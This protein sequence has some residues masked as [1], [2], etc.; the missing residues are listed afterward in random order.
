M[1]P[2]ILGRMFVALVLACA[3]DVSRAQTSGTSPQ[4][5]S[6][7][8]NQS[9]QQ[10]GYALRVNTRVVLTDVTVTDSKGNPVAGLPQSAFHIL[11]NKQPQAIS[12]F[13]EHS[14]PVRVSALPT[15]KPG[16]YSNEYLQHLPAVLNV[17]VLDITN[18][19]VPDQMWLNHELTQFLDDVPNDQPLAIYLRSAENCFLVQNFTSDRTLL[20]NALHKAI[21]RIPPPSGAQLNDFDTM[22]QIAVYLDQLQGRKNVIWF[23]G[24]SP[25]FVRPDADSAAFENAAEWHNLYDELER[26]RIAIYPVDARGLT[27]TSDMGS[28]M[29]EFSQHTVMEDVARATGGHAFYNTNGMVEAATHVLST[30]GSF[31]TLTYSPNNFRF[32]NKWHNVRIDVD[33]GPYQIGYRSGYFADGSGGN[34]QRPAASRTRLLANGAKVEVLPQ[35]R[36]VPIIFEATAMPVTDPALAAWPPPSAATP[37]LLP[38]KPPRKGDTRYS[39]RYSVPVNS[40]VVQNVGGKKVVTFDVAAIGFG[41]DGQTI[42]RQGERA[43]MTL[44]RDSLQEH[45]DGQV[46]IDQQIDLQRGNDYLYLA[47]WDATSGRLGT[48]QVPITVVAPPKQASK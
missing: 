42:A 34:G 7:D 30:D 3:L 23:S 5:S 18:L 38:S 28:I 14:G 46:T 4:S 22:R 25:I 44:N 24:G 1:S 9:T 37:P 35:L 6:L 31:Y 45:P 8:N 32:D 11:D 16:V 21:P 12:S 17:I 43:T 19:D 29:A 48:L 27:V 36:S 10:P 41:H 13:E 20:E 47:V 26:E 15:S 40:L 39:I 33:G 2:Q